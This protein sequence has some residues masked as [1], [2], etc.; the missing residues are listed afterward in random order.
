[1]SYILGGVLQ[2]VFWLVVLPPLLWLCRRYAPWLEAPLFN[3]GLREGVATLIDRV[4]SR[5]QGLQIEPRDPSGH[6]R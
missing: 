4:R 3:M 1:M 6:A 2:V 5:R